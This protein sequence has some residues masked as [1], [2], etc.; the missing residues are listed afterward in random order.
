MTY[1]EAAQELISLYADYVETCA[2]NDESYND[3]S[4]ALVVA[5]E[6]LLIKADQDKQKTMY[7]QALSQMSGVATLTPFR[8]EVQQMIDNSL[9]DL[10]MR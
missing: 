10:G 5:V 8:G 9:D 7:Q 3:Y 1:Q 6:A 2:V 4:E